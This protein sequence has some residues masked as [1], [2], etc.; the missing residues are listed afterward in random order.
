MR[1][2][3]NSYGSNLGLILVLFILLVI[4]ICFFS[5]NS[6]NNGPDDG[7]DDESSEL[8]A[9]RGFTLVNSA[10][11]LNLVVSF[12]K[13]AEE[14]TPTFLPS[15]DENHFRVPIGSTA[16]VIYSVYTTSYASLVGKFSASMYSISLVQDVGFRSISTTA[17]LRWF[18]GIT[19][20]NLV[21]VNK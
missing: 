11:G 16:T 4:T 17:P 7:S 10:E 5:R 12:I 20:S 3:S 21:L 19:P 13:N 2:I 18:Y 9:T 14:P 15:G 8:G 6:V 1:N